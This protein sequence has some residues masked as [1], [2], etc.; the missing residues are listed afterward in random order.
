MARRLLRLWGLYATMDVLFLARG[1]RIAISYYIADFVI[2]LGAVTATFLLA[3]RFDGLGP[4]TRP[5]VIFMLGYALLVRG[6]INTFF[7]FNVAFIS[8]RIGRG[9][10]D[11]ILI[12]PQP[13]WMALFTEGFAPITGSGMLLPAAA[14]LIIA[15]G[16]LNLALSAGWFALLAVNL[17]A[18]IAV[19]LA[20]E[21]AWA[22]IAFWAPRAAEE[23]NSSTWRLLMQLSPFPLEGLS[24]IALTS[25]V[26]VVPVGLVAWYPSRVL[27]GMDASPWALAFLPAAAVLL[28]AL[29][30]WT[31]RRGLH[32]YGRTGSSRYLAWGHRS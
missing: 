19:V 6:L 23:I 16:Q 32:E 30:A 7:T 1:P 24:A 8:R 22:C 3:E 29:A 31:F 9:Q 2:G 12:Q 18:S 20:F 5:Q 25:L 13:L 17:I 26:T 4:W 15:G 28:G 27:L 21:Y 14:L 11:H 10:L